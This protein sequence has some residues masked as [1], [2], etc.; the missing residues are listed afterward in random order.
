MMP[1]VRHAHGPAQD[2]D[3]QEAL[4]SFAQSTGKCQTYSR[5]TCGT[6]SH[7]GPVPP[8]VKLLPPCRCPRAPRRSCAARRLRRRLGS[9][10]GLR[11]RLLRQRRRGGRLHLLALVALRTVC[12]YGCPN[13]V[14]LLAVPVEALLPLNPLALRTGLGGMRS[15]PGWARMGERLWVMSRW[16]GSIDN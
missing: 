1:N 6:R 3:E 12:L 14:A 2:G 7:P 4:P 15:R 13:L 9:G 16:A 11:A 5:P 10:R 8:S